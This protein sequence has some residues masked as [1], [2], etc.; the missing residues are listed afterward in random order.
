[1]LGGVQ[2]IV[3]PY[4]SAHRWFVAFSGGLDSCVLLHFLSHL[5]NTPPI[6]AVYIHHGL[7]QA[8]DDW[9][10]HCQ[11]MAES[12]GVEFLAIKV[13]VDA[14]GN[15]EEH[16][17]EA[18]YQ[19]FS[20][21]L[22][23]EDCLFVGHHADDQAET[24]LYRL[25]RGAG[26]RGLAA[27]PKS[28]VLG[29]GVLVRPLL[30]V[31]LK[32]L[33]AY[34]RQHQLAYV[35]DPSNDETHY[36]RNYLRHQVLPTLATRWPA[37]PKSIARSVGHLREAQIL[38]DELAAEDCK[39][40]ATRQ[41]QLPCFQL[42]D[43][44]NLSAARQSNVLRYWLHQYGVVLS[45][46]QYQQLQEEVIAAKADAMPVLLL[47]DKVIRR[48]QQALYICPKHEVARISPQLWHASKPLTLEGIGTFYLDTPCDVQLTVRPREGGEHIRLPNAKHHK[49]LKQVLQEAQIPPWL[50]DQLPLFYYE[51]QLIAVADI[52][53]ADQAKERL[54]GARILRRN[55]D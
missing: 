36:D 54:Q 52:L 9:Q 48:Y 32:Q 19:A 38:L 20:D 5:D 23:P 25:M 24:F 15:V 7:Q 14:S 27:M 37:M 53:L 35:H 40:Y 44:C 16:A 21:L 13:A 28:R 33:E 4:Y 51:E 55:S 3:L 30:E 31:P 10:A 41:H 47:E 8:A 34:A 11:A 46:Q 45:N 1:M 2:S 26:L 49:K 43:W 39:K 12:V 22:M 29:Q 18:R 42:S 17:R 6:T 50:R